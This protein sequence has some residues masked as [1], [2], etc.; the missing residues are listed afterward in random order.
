MFN[1]TETDPD[2]ADVEKYLKLNPGSFDHIPHYAREGALAAIRHVMELEKSHLFR[3]GLYYILLSDLCRSTEASLQLGAEL[4][5][6]RV[7][8]FILNCIDAL[9]SID[10]Q[11]YAMFLREVGDAVLII[12]SSFSDVLEWY[13]TMKIY[14]AKRNQISSFELEQ[15]QYKQFKLEAKTVVHAGEVFYSDKNIPM[16]FAVNQVFKVEK[17][18]KAGELGVTQTA[19]SSSLPILRG[20]I[21]GYRKRAEVTLP[22]DKNPIKTYLIFKKGNKKRA[23]KRLHKDHS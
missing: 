8:T 20:T 7:E 10:L 16:A 21:F 9:G 18:F 3:P 12:F 23:N 4:N 2:P 17:L 6:L 1:L 5:R 22:G 14:L 15:E 19:L 11:N 13:M